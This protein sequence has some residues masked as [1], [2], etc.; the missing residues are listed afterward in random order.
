MHFR[1][2]RNLRNSRDLS[3]SLDNEVVESVQCFKYLGVTLDIYLSFE[4]HIEKLC[5][6]IN[7]RNG[8]LKRMRNFISKDLAIDLYKSLIEP[9]YRYCDYIYTGCSLTNARKLQVCQN[10]SLRAIS[11]ADQY[12]PTELL[13]KELGIEWLDVQTNKS[14]CI[15]FVYSRISTI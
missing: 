11:R 4:T 5:G 2:C 1:H 8:I 12:Y 15:P 3:I 13:H 10:N 14:L 9:H 7:S 6:K